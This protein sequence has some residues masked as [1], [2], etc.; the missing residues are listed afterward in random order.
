MSFARSLIRAPSLFAGTMARPMAVR[1]ACPAAAPMPTS[2]FRPAPLLL[3]KAGQ[4]KVAKVSAK[5][6][7]LAKGKKGKKSLETTSPQLSVA[8]GKAKAKA[9]VDASTPVDPE[10]PIVD[11]PC[12]SLFPPAEAAA[13]TKERILF[14]GG[15]NM[16]SAMLSALRG[17]Y[18]ASSFM[19]ADGQEAI[20]NT[21]KKEGIATSDSTPD[22]IRTFKPTYIYVC[23][24]P[25]FMEDLSA[26]VRAYIPKNTVI[27]SCVL[28]SDLVQLQNYFGTPRVVRI[29]PNTNADIRRGVVVWIANKDAESG[30]PILSKH[31]EGEMT[32]QLQCMGHELH[33]PSEKY[34]DAATAVAGSGPA[35]YL[36]LLEAATDAAVHLGLPRRLSE[37]LVFATI[38]GTVLRAEGSETPLTVLKQQVATPGGATMAALYKLEQRGLRTVI[39]D[40]MWACYRR[41]LQVGGNPT[42]DVGPDRPSSAD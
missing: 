13:G 35:Y 15:G 39:S 4:F 23:V 21:F 25:H 18:P 3:G 8:V 28:G 16:G 34:I 17:R 22:A 33:L 32:K 31:E 9:K 6:A 30:R 42:S 24:K 36:L 11:C 37:E 26:S 5:D 27:I 19:V 29:M 41:T 7:S 12:K 10:L 20:R 38:L 40:A 1:S 2:M 14:I